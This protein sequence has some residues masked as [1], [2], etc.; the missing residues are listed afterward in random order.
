MGQIIHSFII[1]FKVGM[2]I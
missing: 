1:L 2:I